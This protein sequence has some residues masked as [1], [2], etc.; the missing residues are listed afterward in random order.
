MYLFCNVYA[1]C[2]IEREVTEFALRPPSGYV[3]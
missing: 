1:E 2:E 3:W